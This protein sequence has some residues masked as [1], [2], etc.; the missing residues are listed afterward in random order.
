M[1]QIVEGERKN[2][3]RIKVG[4]LQLRYHAIRA[5]SLTVRYAQP[6]MPCPACGMAVMD[7]DGLLTLVCP[8]CGY[9]QGGCFT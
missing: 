1:N 3:G 9:G 6:G 2:Q 8:Q 4:D 7:Y 5:A